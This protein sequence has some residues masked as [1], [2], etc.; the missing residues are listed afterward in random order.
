[1]TNNQEVR[2][3]DINV[4]RRTNCQEIKISVTDW[5]VMKHV[6]YQTGNHGFASHEPLAKSEHGRDVWNVPIGRCRLI[7]SRIENSVLVGLFGL[8]FDHRSLTGNFT[9]ETC[10][11]GLNV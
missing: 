10:F 9:S 2:I 8:E 6:R 7:S 11:A 5:R 1:M 3:K 4:Y